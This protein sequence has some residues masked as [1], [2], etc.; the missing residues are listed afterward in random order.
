MTVAELVESFELEVINEA[1]F[2]REAVGAYSGD[3]LSWV[4]TRLEADNA[5][6]TIMNNINVVAVASLA[7]AACVIF[8]ENAEI[9]AD[10]TDKAR[11]QGINLL[12]TKKSTFEISYL[13]GKM[14]YAE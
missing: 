2:S 13:L 6:I 10:V 8:T 14:L 1:D 7:D 12:R 11:L 4:M 9:G 5:W 3:L